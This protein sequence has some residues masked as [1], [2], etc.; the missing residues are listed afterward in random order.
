MPVACVTDASDA[1]TDRVDAQ[2]SP[3]SSVPL[4]LKMPTLRRVGFVLFRGTQGRAPSAARLLPPESMRPALPI[5]REPGRGRRAGRERQSL[6]ERSE[7]SPFPAAGTENLENPL[8]LKELRSLTL[9]QARQKMAGFLS[10]LSSYQAFPPA[11]AEAHFHN[12]DMFF[13]R[14]NYGA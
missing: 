4:I 8:K 10:C 3:V 9:E 7:R 11:S 12:S 5:S 2:S 13:K 6:R 1:T 14:S